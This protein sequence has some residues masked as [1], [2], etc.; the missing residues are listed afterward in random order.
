MVTILALN[1]GKAI[2]EDAAIKVTI[3]NLSYIRAEKTIPLS[4]ALIINLLKRLK[5]VFHALV[6]L[7]NL[8]VARTINGKSIG[9]WLFSPVKGDINIR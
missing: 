2:M 6:I 9:H 8:R 4:K 7:R 1:T 5:M 3:N